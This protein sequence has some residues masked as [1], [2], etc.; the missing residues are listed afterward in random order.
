MM[1]DSRSDGLL[2]H[3]L[4]RLRRDWVA[5]YRAWTEVA[6]GR[7]L[8]SIGLTDE[9]WVMLRRYRAAETAYFAHLRATDSELGP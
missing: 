1:I 9:Q 3:D 2:E 6:D 4:A 8:N 7:A 5:A